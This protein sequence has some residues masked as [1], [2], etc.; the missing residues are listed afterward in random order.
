MTNKTYVPS[1]VLA[2]TVPEE[3]INGLYIGLQLNS[4]SYSY[5]VNKYSVKCGGSFGMWESSS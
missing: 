5:D 1:E 4:S 3:W 2:D